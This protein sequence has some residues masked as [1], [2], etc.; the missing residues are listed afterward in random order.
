MGKQATSALAM[1]NHVFIYYYPQGLMPPAVS[2]Y[3]AVLAG[4][5]DNNVTSD[6]CTVSHRLKQYQ[7][8]KAVYLL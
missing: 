4:F 5:C 2:Y 3:N 7:D 6:I 1:I 8:F